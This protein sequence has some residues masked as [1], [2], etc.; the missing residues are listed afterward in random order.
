M[1]RRMV[2]VGDKTRERTGQTGRD[3]EE[4]KRRE[5]ERHLPEGPR[6]AE[7]R[8]CAVDPCSSADPTT[9]GARQSWVTSLGLRVLLHNVGGHHVSPNCRSCSLS[10]EAEVQTQR[11]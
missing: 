9:S 10:L 1:G 4:G 7:G 8:I 11:G 3:T 2:R 6:E 5:A